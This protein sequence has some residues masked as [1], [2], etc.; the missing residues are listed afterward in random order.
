MGNTGITIQ[1]ISPILGAEISGVNLAKPLDDET[2]EAIHGALM[3]HLAIFFRDQEITME[4][5]KDFGR[6]FGDLHV[7]PAA[8]AP[9]G[10][11]EILVIHADENSKRVAGH[12]WH[13]DVSCDAEPPMGSILYLKTVPSVG[14]D[15]MFANM[16]AAYEALSA[17]MQKYLSGLTA[18]HGSEHVY[19]GRYGQTENLRDGDYPES[20]HP[21]VRSHPVTGRKCL[22]VN[23]SFTTRIKGV[24]RGESKAILEFLYDHVRTPEFHCRFNW[25]ANSIAFWDNRCA[26]HHALWDYYPE[27]RHGYR[28]TIQ[29]DRPYQ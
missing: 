2:F 11:P 1:P 22:F 24:S 16:Y 26:Q 28:V 27:V 14:G 18:I 12:A 3:Q 6:L 29:G 17:G 25:Q 21:I 8:P 20:E 19:R 4:Q 13:S 10:H 23:S 7:H 5:H 9:A 15:T